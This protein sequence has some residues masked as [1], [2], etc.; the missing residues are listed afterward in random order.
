[1]ISWWDH[2]DLQPLIS[3]L[4]LLS[5]LDTSE[6]F[7][8]ALSVDSSGGAGHA[9]GPLEGL[10]FSPSC[11]TSSKCFN[12][13][14]EL[15]TTLCA[16]KLCWASPQPNLQ[17]IRFIICLTLFWW[18]FFLFANACP[19]LVALSHNF[20]QSSENAWKKNNWIQ[21]CCCIVSLTIWDVINFQSSSW[22]CQTSTLKSSYNSACNSLLGKMLSSLYVEPSTGFFCLSKNKKCV[23]SENICTLLGSEENMECS[24]PLMIMKM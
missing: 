9:K 3:S 2:S 21:K 11:N 6:K 12:A 10:I 1:M 17:S 23:L 20:Y 16:D 5:D 4:L 18:T 22:L 24:L 13:R 7:Y 19:S 15:N 8:W 14:H